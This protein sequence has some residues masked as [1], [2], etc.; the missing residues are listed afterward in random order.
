MRL[1]SNSRLGLL[2]NLSKPSLG[3]PRKS[4][5]PVKPHSVISADQMFQRLEGLAKFDFQDIHPSQLML[6]H[7]LSSAGH[8]FSIRPQNAPL[9]RF[10]IK[11]KASGINVGVDPRRGDA[12]VIQD[13]LGEK[14]SATTVLV[15]PFALEI[16]SFGNSCV[17]SFARMSQLKKSSQ[18]EKFPGGNIF[19]RFKFWFL[20]KIAKTI[21]IWFYYCGEEPRIKW[22]LNWWRA[23]EISLVADYVSGNISDICFSSMPAEAIAEV[24]LRVDAER[25]WFDFQFEFLGYKWS[26]HFSFKRLMSTTYNFQFKSGTGIMLFSETGANLVLHKNDGTCLRLEFDQ[27][28]NNKRYIILHADGTKSLGNHAIAWR[29]KAVFLS[30]LAAIKEYLVAKNHTAIF[31]TLFD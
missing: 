30:D 19:D 8:C 7:K 20:K 13:N 4:S 26:V 1:I 6:T 15:S 2:P 28:G 11:T 16:P 27:E 24:A 18:W 9:S 23:K 17:T 25:K 14:E 3:F 12:V 5:K 29:D 21:P 10:S 31:K 22:S